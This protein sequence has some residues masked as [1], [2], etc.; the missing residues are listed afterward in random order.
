VVGH[1]QLSRPGS[2]KLL[3]FGPAPS[4]ALAATVTRHARAGRTS[5]RLGPRPG[6]HPLDA[7]RYL[8]RV[9][10]QGRTTELKAGLLVLPQ[11]RVRALPAA[12]VRLKGCKSEHN[13]AIAAGLLASNPLAAMGLLGQRSPGL[14]PV[15]PRPK[16]PAAPSVGNFQALPSIPNAPP[17]KSSGGAVGAAI[18]WALVLLLVGVPVVGIAFG[19]AHFLRARHS[20]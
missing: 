4:C 17:G 9:R 20:A 8:I 7:G 5:F 6:G 13:A 12:K 3:F 11:H 15:R 1:L 18:F 10:V 2:F 19:A 16:P 14:G